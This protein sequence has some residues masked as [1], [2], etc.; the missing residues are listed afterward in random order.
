LKAN[1]PKKHLNR[2][3]AKSAMENHSV[4]LIQVFQLFVSN[5]S[6]HSHLNFFV[7]FASLRLLTVGFRIIGNLND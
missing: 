3:D 7:P 2:K 4:V 5:R 1:Y 6:V